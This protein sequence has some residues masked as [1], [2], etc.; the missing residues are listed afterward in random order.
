MSRS[1]IML[2]SGVNLIALKAMANVDV[3]SLRKTG[4]SW[5]TIGK[6]NCYKQACIVKLPSG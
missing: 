3:R 4:K 1:G 5:P 6:Q 2:N